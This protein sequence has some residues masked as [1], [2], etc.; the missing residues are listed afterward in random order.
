MV[1]SIVPGASGATGAAVEPRYTRSQPSAHQRGEGAAKGDR[2]DLSGAALAGV[3]ESV[4]A[5]IAQAHEALA[6]GHDAQAVLVQAQ[7]LARAGDQ[8]G[9]SRLLEGF[10]QRLEAAIAGGAGVLAGED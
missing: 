6:A 10:N 4:R 5:G 8:A 1:S 2:V 9:L 7:A 3:R